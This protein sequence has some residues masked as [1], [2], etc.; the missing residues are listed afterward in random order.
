MPVLVYG[1]A[2]IVFGQPTGHEK[3]SGARGLKQDCI[4]LAPPPIPN[5]LIMNAYQQQVG[6]RR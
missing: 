1:V 3:Y 4:E 5:E 6:S 2:V